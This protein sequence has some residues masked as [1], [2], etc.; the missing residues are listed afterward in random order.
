MESPA[1]NAD[2]LAQDELWAAEAKGGLRQSASVGVV[3]AWGDD[4]RSPSVRSASLL[5]ETFA[6]GPV[7]GR[8]G[9]KSRCSQPRQPEPQPE[10]DDLDLGPEVHGGERL[11]L[12][13]EP[14]ETPAT[15][16]LPSLVRF[17]SVTR[18]LM[19]NTTGITRRSA[20]RP[21]CETISRRRAGSLLPC[22]ARAEPASTNAS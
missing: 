8:F 4:R 11:D 5:P 14:F 22:V 3:D 13:I 9:R 2:D 18:S 17:P 15:R 20:I 16:L 12:D 21:Y 19:P 7:R 6:A 10:P 1:P